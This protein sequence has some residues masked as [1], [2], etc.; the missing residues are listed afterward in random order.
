[1][2]CEY[3]QENGQYICIHCGFT[4]KKNILRNCT[5]GPNIL[6]KAINFLPAVTGHVMDGLDKCSEEEIKERLD[7]CKTC[8][9]FRIYTE[10]PLH[11][12][13]THESCGCNITD[14]KNFLNKLA[15]K[16]QQCPINKWKKL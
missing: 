14:Q 9:L 7:I 4:A 3:K 1:M 16:S 15:W 12:I 8:E 6:Q 11:G 10:N 13:C 2:N 5:R